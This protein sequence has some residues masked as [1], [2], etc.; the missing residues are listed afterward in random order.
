MFNMSDICSMEHH[1]LRV[2]SELLKTQFL[3]TRKILDIEASHVQIT[4]HEL[5]EALKQ[6]HG[7][8]SM[9]AK[10]P[11]LTEL[12][13]ILEARL[14]Q[15]RA[16]FHE[17]VSQE[18]AV[19]QCCKQRIDHLKDGCQSTSSSLSESNLGTITDLGRV[20]QKT[21]LDR[22]LVEHFLR[23]GYYN[24][25][26]ALAQTSRIDG[27]TN[28]NIFVVAKDVEEA[29]MREDTPKCLA[30]CRNNKGKLRKMKST[31]EE[32]VENHL[33]YKTRH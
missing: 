4:A 8:S 26:I 15:M 10:Q 17:A 21:R 16:K 19:A 20:W 27:L 22:M 11:N 33:R 25:A 1:T 18:V 14:V 24:S 7:D 3:S 5:V 32:L 23:S 30:W 13:E 28:T 29:L 6:D 9:Q 12:L 2:P 31:L